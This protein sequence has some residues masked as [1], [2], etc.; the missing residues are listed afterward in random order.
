MCQTNLINTLQHSNNQWYKR[1]TY[2]LHNIISSSF[3]SLLGMSTHCKTLNLQPDLLKIPQKLFKPAVGQEKTSVHWF[4]MLFLAGSASYIISNS[5]KWRREKIKKSHPK[6][7][8]MPGTSLDW[9]HPW[10]PSFFFVR[11]LLTVAHTSPPLLRHKP[12]INLKIYHSCHRGEVV[13]LRSC[14][15]YKLTNSLNG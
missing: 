13:M 6:H 3:Q 8:R 14:S 2:R 4:K 5:G 12:E 10:K 11:M 7:I 1:G 9:R 15:K